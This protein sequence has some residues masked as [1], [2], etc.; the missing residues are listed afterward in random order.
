MSQKYD[1]C[2]LKSLDDYVVF[3]LETTGLSRDK[4]DI[5]EI[6]AIRYS[7]G[8]KV[9]EFH[10]LVR[11]SKPIP[12]EVVELTGITQADVESAPTFYRMLPGFYEFIEGLPLVGHNICTFDIPFL[13][14]KLA[15]PLPNMVIDTLYLSRD[16]FPGLPKYS[17]TYLNESLGLCSDCAHR[18]LADVETANS[19]FLACRNSDSFLLKVSVAEMTCND[20]VASHQKKNYLSSTYEYVDYR[21][22]VPQCEQI[23]PNHPLYKKRV[24]FT[25]VLSISRA[26][27]MQ[28]AVNAGAILRNSI[29]GK[30]AYLVVGTQDIS[31]VGD[32]GM[33]CKET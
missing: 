17:L 20:S 33:S 19:L 14:A 9:Q 2:F 18:A 28:R 23:N 15:T 13:N 5:I 3:D 26:E 1:Y 25:G 8:Q 11:P 7:H 32:D 31:V 24:V 10:S 4:D 21:A 6:A 30:T 22:I 16:I 29:S 12:Q 27:A